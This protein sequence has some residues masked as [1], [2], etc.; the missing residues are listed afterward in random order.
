MAAAVAGFGALA[1]GLWRT[2][3]PVT[4]ASAVRSPGLWLVASVGVYAFF[5][6]AI[7]TASNIDPLYSRYLH[8]SYAFVV[9]AVACLYSRLVERAPDAWERW[10][11]LLMLLIAYV[12]QVSKVLRV[13]F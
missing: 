5:M 11:L 1:W 10:P 7:W 13:A 8:P 4:R 3:T 9:L 2:R 12:A 6:V